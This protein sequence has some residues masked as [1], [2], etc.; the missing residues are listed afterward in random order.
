MK[1]S[2]KNIEQLEKIVEELEHRLAGQVE[3]QKPIKK[4]SLIKWIENNLKIRPKSGGLEPFKPNKFQKRV[5]AHVVKQF[6]LKKPV[7][8]IVLKSRQLGISTVIQAII[9]YF[10]HHYPE[11]KAAVVAHRKDSAEEIFMMTRRFLDNLPDHETKPLVGGRTHKNKLVYAG[12][13]N[14]QYRVLTAGADEIGRGET[15]QFVHASEEAFYRDPEIVL[16]GLSQAVPKLTDTWFSI[17]A[18]E[19]TANGRNRFKSDWDQAASPDSI[20][21]RFFI[22]W[23]DDPESRI[24]AP[25]NFKK[26]SAEEEYAQAHNLDDQQI[27]WARNTRMNECG[28]SWEKFHQEYP[29]SPQLAFQYSG[30]PV[31]DQGIL[32]EL[33]LLSEERDAVFR[34]DIRFKSTTYPIVELIKQPIGPLTIW[35]HSNAEYEYV[36]GADPAHGIGADYSEIVVLKKD[37]V[38]VVAHWR[39][40]LVPPTEFGIRCWQLGAYYGFGLLGIERNSV[41]LSTLGVVERGL[42]DYPQMM[43]YPN[44]YYET[45]IDRKTLEETQ[46]LGFNTSRK[47]KENAINRLA[48]LVRSGDVDIPSYP[49]LYQMQGFQW[50]PEQKKFKQ[51]NIDPV[52]ELPNDDGIIA[53]ALANEMRLHGMFSR[54]CRPAARPNY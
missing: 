35:E 14:S 4:Q 45:K 11:I 51:D 42:K 50:E 32:E 48:E 7:R 47:T 40:N 16:T 23:K 10:V 12:P 8:I 38:V 21:K 27:L 5:V 46:Q 6:N 31:F 39:S 34:G 20:W 18:K 44:I 9:L 28:G 15:I 54:W 53:A 2:E 19:S 17:F 25:A 36:L 30:W 24:P 22:S 41:G 37:P 49:L 43:K 26:D 33:V 3:S 13:H 52:S 1:T 29:V